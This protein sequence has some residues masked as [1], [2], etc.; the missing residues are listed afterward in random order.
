MTLRQLQSVFAHR[1]ARLIL[2]AA[3]LGYEVTLGEA[4]RSPEE[5]ERLA[6]RKSGRAIKRSLHCDRLAIDL[7]LF[8]DGVFLTASDDHLPLGEYWE[9]LSDDIAT[10]AWG[11]RFDDANHYSIAYQ[12]RK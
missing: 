5:A 10:C 3:S 11:G 4:W 6:S 9:S 8:R 7:N 12:G 2:H 1:V